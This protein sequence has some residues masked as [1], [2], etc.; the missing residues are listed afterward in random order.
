MKKI[1]SILILFT[2]SLFAGENKIIQD[3]IDVLDKFMKIY[4]E[5]IPTQILD[6]AEAI[7]IFPHTIKAGF[8]VGGRYGKGIILVKNRNGIWSNPIFAKIAGGSIGWQIGAVSIDLILVFKSREKIDEI[9]KGKI[10]LGADASVAAGPVGRSTM[11]STD[12]K[13]DSEIYSYSRSKGIFAGISLQGSNISVDYES[14][15]NF[16]KTADIKRILYSENIPNKK[17]IDSIKERLYQYIR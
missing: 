6:E 12:I 7:A 1:F 17:L 16:Y 8:I 11:A 5:E 15:Q 10:T 13:L 3:S 4:E 9:I 14:I 2:F